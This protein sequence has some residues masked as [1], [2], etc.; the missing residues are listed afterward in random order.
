[1]NPKKENKVEKVLSD[2]ELSILSNIQSMIGELTNMNAGEQAGEATGV[3]A[4][5]EEEVAMQESPMQTD[6]D[7]DGTEEDEIAVKKEE[8]PTADDDTETRISDNLP[9]TT[10][11]NIDEV[12]KALLKILGGEKV[13]KSKPVDPVLAAIEGLTKVV[14]SVYA[15]NQQTQSAVAN[16]IEGLGITEQINLS[17]PV[18][19]SKPA[20]S[21]DTKNLDMFM[22]AV[23]KAAG[24]E[25]VEP[26]QKYDSPSG[27]VHKTM[28]N[29][30]TSGIVQ[31]NAPGA[32]TIMQKK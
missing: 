32:R 7:Q 9:E 15:E 12:K 10:D 25:N 3:E 8:G 5:A 20:Q 28:K 2:Q 27:E 11:E 19:K 4:P 29:F 1:M 26:V 16:I 22:N 30:L 31:L 17:Q 23:R 6:E 18:Q 24:I 13:K 21:I 14:K